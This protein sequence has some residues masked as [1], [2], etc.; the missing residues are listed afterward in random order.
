MD[1]PGAAVLRVKLRYPTV[2]AFID[3]Y[4][5]N[6][7]RS[8]I[9]L[10][11][12]TEQTVGNEVRFELRIATDKAVIIGVGKVLAIRPFDPDQ[13]N[14]AFGVIVELSRV[15]KD[16]R[17]VI[18][19]ILEVRKQ[20]G[21]HDAPLPIP[22][23]TRAS[24][25]TLAAPGIRPS[26]PTGAVISAPPLPQH[27]LGSL[28]IGAVR[29]LAAEPPRK[30]RPNV[31]QAMASIENAS[32]D[33]FV[34]EDGGLPEMTVDL[35]S[36]ISLA[37]AIL[38]QQEGDSDLQLS[39]LM[40]DA[41]IPVAISVDEA[42]AELAKALGVPSVR[43]G[44]RAPRFAAI[45]AVPVQHSIPVDKLVGEAVE[46]A[47]AEWQHSQATKMG[48]SEDY[49]PVLHKDADDG[50]EITSPISVEAVVKPVMPRSTTSSGA[51]RV[52][53]NVVPADPKTRPS[54][55]PPVSNV[56]SMNNAQRLSTQPRSSTMVPPAPAA[57]HQEFAGSFDAST[58]A[59]GPG[60]AD[61]LAIT[62]A[63][64][65]KP[66]ALGSI[67]DVD[68]DHDF[69][70]DFADDN[71]MQWKQQQATVAASA[72][73]LQ[74]VAARN[75]FNAFDIRS[76]R[77]PQ[78]HLDHTEAL[79]ESDIEDPDD[80][81]A[82]PPLPSVDSRDSVDRTAVRAPEQMPEDPRTQWDDP[83]LDFA[84]P[85][86]HEPWKHEQKTV[87]LSQPKPALAQPTARI[88]EAVAAPRFDSQA[89]DIEFGD[90]AMATPLSAAPAIIT[91]APRYTARAGTQDAS[92]LDIVEEQ[93]F[94]EQP[95][96]LPRQDFELEAPEAAP[97][98]PMTDDDIP[99]ELEFDDV[100]IDDEFT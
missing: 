100:E 47:E 42:S 88:A 31:A 93:T 67:H 10:P 16:S 87:A 50:D 6:V 97:T 27:P 77:A 96:V 74:T 18:Q 8:G 9:F 73:M 69:A 37:K 29:T 13:T 48:S 60:L 4:V 75:D 17:E 71:A 15:T 22:L 91:P 62:S 53:P 61:L 25:P 39:D 78:S 92:E 33:F 1:E 34:V 44:E 5:M 86:R 49:H 35:P 76:P 56:H 68:D 3:K 81:L 82:P 85:V 83:D 20:R 79:I 32:P 55:V 84:T 7:G 57:P 80:P 45:P 99:I 24:E 95:D 12:K 70:R 64:V 89:E 59:A 30:I 19:K 66:D 94:F 28:H 11:T 58:R 23:V 14:V 46:P 65:E 43:R 52:S 90:F 54:T 51:H 63:P 2:E 26:R 38:S 98:I 36:S 41:A 21:M 72:A 40:S